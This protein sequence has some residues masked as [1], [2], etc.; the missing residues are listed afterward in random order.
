MICS[1]IDPGSRSFGLGLP[2]GH[3]PVPPNSN[4]LT[5]SETAY[6]TQG[7]AHPS[8]DINVMH[9]LETLH[10]ILW[11]NKRPPTFESCAHLCADRSTVGSEL[12]ASKAIASRQVSRQADPSAPQPLFS[13]PISRMPAQSEASHHVSSHSTC[14]CQ[15]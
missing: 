8:H 7:I 14:T 11:S 1:V 10:C 12:T 5:I 6:S 9:R 15:T 13:A 4:S 2:H 3:Q